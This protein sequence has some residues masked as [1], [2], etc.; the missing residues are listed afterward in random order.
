MRGRNNISRRAEEEERKERGGGG[1]VEERGRWRD[2]RKHGVKE[3][4]GRE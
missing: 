4:G 1:G 3:K 2:E